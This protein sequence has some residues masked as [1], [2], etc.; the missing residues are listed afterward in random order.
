MSYTSQ[1]THLMGATISLTIQHDDAV[2]ILGQSFQLLET[3]EYRFNANSSDSELSRINQE[4]GIRP[5]IVHPDL[6]ELISIG[7]KH[8]LA[9]NSQMNI[10][11]GPLVQT[12][13]IGFSDAKVPTDDEIHHALAKIDPKKIIL[14]E[15]NFSIFL[16]EKGMKID[17]G[18]LAK[19]YSADKLAGFLRSKG[20]TSALINLGGNILTIGSKEGKPWKIGLQA[21]QSPNGHHLGIIPIVNQS[22]VT[23]GTYVRHL[24][25][26]EHDFHHIFDSSTG[27]PCH[28]DLRSLTILSE[29]SIDGEIWT[30]RLFGQNEINILWQIEQTPNIEAILVDKHGKITLSSGLDPLLPTK[31]KEL[32]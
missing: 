4:A 19:G 20:V 26:E 27:Y 18:C 12:W 17:L 14:D 2:E 9:E 31:R 6:F 15:R 28:T 25:T 10:A 24:K 29:Q 13:R 11:I 3:L 21:P 32:L 22:V 30:T 16:A 5:V 1:S 8:S 7:K 23:S